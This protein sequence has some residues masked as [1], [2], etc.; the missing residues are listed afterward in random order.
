[1]HTL[2]PL[3]DPRDLL[4]LAVVVAGIALSW[5]L[6]RWVTAW[7]GAALAVALLSAVLVVWTRW[8][9]LALLFTRRIT[10][11]LVPVAATVL[12]VRVALLLPRLSERRWRAPVLLVACGAAVWGVV[13]SVHQPSPA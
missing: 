7:L 5:S 6:S 10:A 8:T 9:S 3:W 2:W 11:V 1:H 4:L 12:A 13:D